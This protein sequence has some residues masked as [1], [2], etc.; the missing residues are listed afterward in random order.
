MISA[1]QLA[2]TASLVIESLRVDNLS[3]TAAQV[4][5]EL[6][7]TRHSVFDQAHS[8]TILEYLVSD[9]GTTRVSSIL[10]GDFDDENITF[11]EL[12]LA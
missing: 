8:N 12:L 11:L 7:E 5:N 4:L 3:K 9:I 10:E 1:H 6:I 2:S